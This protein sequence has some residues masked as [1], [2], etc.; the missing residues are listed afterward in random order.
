MKKFAVILSGC[1]Q[2]DGT[3]LHEGIYTITALAQ[4]GI[5]WE[6]VAP[7]VEQAL[8]FDHYH[9]E[10]TTDKRN[11][12][13][14]SARF[15]RNK[16]IKSIR[17][18]KANEYQGIIVPGGRGAVMNLSNFTEK[19][20]E[21]SIQEDVYAFLKEAASHK[22]PMGFICIASILVPK[23]YQNAKITIG[24]AEDLA[25]MIHEMGCIHENCLANEI[26]VD[27]KHLVVSTPANMVAKSCL[28]VLEGIQRLVNKLNEFCH[29]ND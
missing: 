6:A 5:A 9:Q 19:G 7:D 10:R 11:I 17:E 15:V 3:E 23:L 14:E 22:I 2:Y 28:E 24:N 13:V 12:L 26:V 16:N 8:V 1:G 27:E 25:H 29:D 4:A 20:L 21:F 18:V